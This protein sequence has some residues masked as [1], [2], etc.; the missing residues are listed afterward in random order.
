MGGQ[1][2]TQH[3][4]VEVSVGTQHWVESGFQEGWPGV[5]GLRLRCELACALCP[6]PALSHTSIKPARPR[7]VSGG[8]GAQTSEVGMDVGG[9]GFGPHLAASQVSSPL[10][11]PVW[12]PWLCE[13][14]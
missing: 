1:A 12:N 7:R 13:Q 3:P 4:A 8:Q 14:A 5:V 2:P 6:H 10:V 11:C 9:Q